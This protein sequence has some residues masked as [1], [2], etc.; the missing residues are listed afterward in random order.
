M[1][2]L[3]F[4]NYS[5]IFLKTLFNK[6]QLWPYE[7]M[8]ENKPATHDFITF[9]FN[10]KFRLILLLPTFWADCSLIWSIN[11]Y[12]LILFKSCFDFQAVDIFCNIIWNRSLF[13]Q[14]F[15]EIMGNCCIFVANWQKLIVKI[16][17]RGGRFDIIIQWEKIFL[18]FNFQ[19][20]HKA[21]K[22]R[23]SII[24][25]RNSGIFTYVWAS[26]D[27]NFFIQFVL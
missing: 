8:T 4:I 7:S 3:S 13:M 27:H 15:T 17:K 18:I 22:L 5:K 10:L 21:L 25:N 2:L 12:Y 20:L 11:L 24:K 23:I 19:S 9:D 26:Q 1:Q 6:S 14:Y 16:I